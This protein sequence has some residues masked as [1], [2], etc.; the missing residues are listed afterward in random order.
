MRVF[1]TSFD[2]KTDKPAKSRPDADNDSPQLRVDHELLWTKKLN[3]GVLFAPTAPSARRNGYLIY[4]DASGERH[5]YGS[6]AITNSYTGWLTP[7]SLAGAVA[8]LSPAQRSR[9]LNPPYT[10]GSAMI[11]P[12]KSQEPYTINKARRSIGDRMDL[13]LEC[14]R[15]HYAGEGESPLTAVLNAYADFLGLFNGFEEFVDF[16]H[17][18]DLVTPDYSKIQ[19]YLPFESFEHPRT[20]VT[21]TEYVTYREAT[22]EFVARRGRRMAEWVV[23]NHPEI[24]VR[25]QPPSWTDGGGLPLAVV[26][27]HAQ[28]LPH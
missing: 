17:L 21:A 5:W 14:I 18:Q 8:S 16:F 9:Y 10:I 7:N 25:H 27:S 28:P 3:S 13:T 19:F 2:Y 11:W 15:R 23:K 1:D 6:D 22:L 4:T 24:E 20:P 26:R 12:V